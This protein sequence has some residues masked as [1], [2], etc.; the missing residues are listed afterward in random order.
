V[1]G[2]WVDG[3][4]RQLLGAGAA[5]RSGG[6]Q[7]ARAG[8][9]GESREVPPADAGE[10]GGQVSVS[11]WVH[12]SLRPQREK[13]AP[14]LSCAAVANLY[15]L[16]VMLDPEAPQERQGEILGNI[17]TMV[18]TGGG[19]VV[20]HHDWGVRRIAFEID[21]RPEAAYHLYQF[22]TDS[23]DTLDRLNHNLRIAD[24]VLRFRIIK[25]KPGTP[26]PPAPRQEAPRPTR[27]RPQETR[28]AARAAAD[29]DQPER[30]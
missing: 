21:H 19:S 8:Y 3:Q 27:E 26:P 4:R 13:L 2:R 5:A 28:V 20:G 11:M 1:R 16:M 22:E 6:Y 12:T 15:D 30:E 29:A 9:R 24:G 23:N 18:Q 17:E 14:L 10:Q 7:H 25:V